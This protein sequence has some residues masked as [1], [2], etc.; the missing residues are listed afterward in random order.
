MH[1]IINMD[2]PASF[3]YRLDNSLFLVNYPETVLVLID[4]IHEFGKLSALLSAK[5]NPSS[6][7]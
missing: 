6:C 7:G 4:S 5:K 3:C 2:R 1:F